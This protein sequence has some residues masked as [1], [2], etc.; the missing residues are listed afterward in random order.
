VCGRTPASRCAPRDGTPETPA[1]TC[2]GCGRSWRG[3]QLRRTP[4]REEGKK[5]TGQGAPPWPV[6]YLQL[7][8]CLGSYR[9]ARLRRR[10]AVPAIPTSVVANSIRA[11]GSGTGAG[12]S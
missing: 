10:R 9:I 3:I 1:A 5:Q 8:I 6:G 7:G 4:R 12:G 11:P 2:L